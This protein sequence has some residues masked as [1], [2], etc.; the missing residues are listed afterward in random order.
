MTTMFQ[1]TDSDLATY[2]FARSFSLLQVWKIGD[3]TAFVF[4]AAAELS[5]RAY[6]QG[7]CVPAKNLLHAARQLNSIQRKTV[8]AYASA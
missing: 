8:N 7:A 4:P 5:A 1:T 2:L 3:L 6:Y